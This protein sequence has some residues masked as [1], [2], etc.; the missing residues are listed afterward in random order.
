VADQLLVVAF[1]WNGVDLT[2]L[3]KARWMSILDVTQERLNRR[4]SKVSRSGTIFSLVLD[5]YQ[6]VLDHP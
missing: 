2:D 4:K 5:V 1:V 6:E 3:L